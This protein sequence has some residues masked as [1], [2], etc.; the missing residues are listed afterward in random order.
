MSSSLTYLSLAAGSCSPRRQETVT[1]SSAGISELVPTLRYLVILWP[2]LIH[3]SM[4]TCTV[5]I[6]WRQFLADVWSQSDYLQDA[7]GIRPRSIG[8]ERVVVGLLSESHYS[9]LV[10]LVAMLMLRWQV[11]SL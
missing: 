11:S 3:P 10:N 5:S 9:F 4:E 2:L 1:L 6:T 7:A 8:S